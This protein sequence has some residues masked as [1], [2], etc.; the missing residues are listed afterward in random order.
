[1]PDASAS[2]ASASQNDGSSARNRREHNQGNQERKYTA[3]QKAAVLRIRRCQPTAFYEIL[4]VQKTCSDGEIKKAYRKLSLLT[5]PDKNGHEHADE[6][7]KMVARAFSVLGD[8]EKREKY[9]RF[10]TD[11][12]SR[13]ASAQ[14]QAQAQNPFAGF[15]GR[16][17]GGGGGGGAGMWGEEE[18]SPEEMFARFFGG[19][20][21]G[22]PFGGGFDAGPQFVFNFGG[23]GIRVHQFGGARPRG[24]PRNPGQEEPASTWS[25]LVGLLPILLLVIWPLL[26]SIFSG[27][28]SS[29]T[30]ATPSMVFDDPHPPLYTVERTMPNLKVK[31]YLNPADIQSYSPSKLYSLDKKAEVLLVQQLRSR[32]E[33]EM[34][35][36]RQLQEA[37]QGW[38]FPDP[39]KME[40]A[41][42]YPMPACQRLNTL[43][44]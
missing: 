21:F 17:A 38:F 26:S 35:H 1:M 24:R 32:C 36:K 43:R 41:N 31:Y 44:L 6:A 4:D 3:E 23:P 9:D 8:K 34:A 12:D 18:I 10:G 37:A 15:A 22:G 2:G 27:I 42:A 29:S 40:V 11:P 14:A 19:G 20:G 7:F 28:T 30:P 25:T 33:S 13:F 5:H 16:R 39:E